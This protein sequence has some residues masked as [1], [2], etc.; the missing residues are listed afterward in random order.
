MPRGIQEDPISI[1]CGLAGEQPGPKTNCLGFSLVKVIDRKV[2]VH[3]LRHGSISPRRRSI[4][5]C[6]HGRDPASSRPYRNELVAGHGH[7]AA[8]KRRPKLRQLC[9][10]LAVENYGG[11]SSDSHAPIIS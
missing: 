11:E 10:V 6:P 7:L 9:R 1:R 5:R 8:D 2:D 4:V 3:L